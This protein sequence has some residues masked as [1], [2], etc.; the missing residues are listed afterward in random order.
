[1]NDPRKQS[2]MATPQTPHAMLMP[3]HGTT[4]TRRKTDNLTQA[5]DLVF[6]PS[7]VSPSRASRVISRAFG[8]KCVKNG[9][10]GV[11]SSVAHTEPIAV[12]SVRTSVA[13]VVGNSA[14]AK[15]FCEHAVIKICTRPP[16]NVHTHMTL[17]GIDQ[18]CFHTAEIVMTPMTCSRGLG[19]LCE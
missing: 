5:E 2:A 4:P 3:D 18:A 10:S 15:T 11:A 12:R 7:S 19:P 17:P 16:E 6:V 9:A 1:M 13:Q 8:N 14:P